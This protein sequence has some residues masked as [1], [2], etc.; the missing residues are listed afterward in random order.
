MKHNHASQY[1]HHRLDD[2]KHT[3][4]RIRVF[5]IPL[6]IPVVLFPFLG[7]GISVISILL[8]LAV[9]CWIYRE[10][11]KRRNAGTSYQA[12][13]QKGWQQTKDR[14]QTDI[15]FRNLLILSASGLL[16]LFLLYPPIG[17]LGAIAAAYFVLISPNR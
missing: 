3:I 12:T 5:P 11:R 6:L 4:R 10:M 8:A 7:P 14:A 13:I 16:C 2:M 15:R 9:S 1:S 17:I